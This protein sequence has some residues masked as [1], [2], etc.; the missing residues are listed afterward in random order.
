MKAQTREAWEH[1]PIPSVSEDFVTQIME[2]AV[3]PTLQTLITRG[4]DYRGVLYAG[5][6]NTASGPN[7]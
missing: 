1:I 3:Q 2:E 5:I 7:S 4:I 6:M